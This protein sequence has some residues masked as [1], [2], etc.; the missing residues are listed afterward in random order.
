MKL[1]ENRLRRSFFMPG[2]E[3]RT[4][5]GQGDGLRHL[6]VWSQILEPGAQMP[7]HYHD[8]EEV[9]VVQRGHGRLLTERRDVRFGPGCTLPIPAEV[10]HQL[11]NDGDEPVDLIA[12]FACSPS[13]CFA[14]DGREIPMPWQPQ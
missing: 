7:V 1:I 6:E 3:H 8:C 9:V 4:L 2:I 11:I 10:V 5:A 13:R 14:L 12:V